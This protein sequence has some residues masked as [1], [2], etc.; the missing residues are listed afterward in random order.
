MGL[1][2]LHSFSRASDVLIQALIGE[3]AVANIKDINWNALAFKSLAIN[4]DKKIV[5]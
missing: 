4:K 1:S 5:L 2:F 3:F